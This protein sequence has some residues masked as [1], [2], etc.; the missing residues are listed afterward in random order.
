MDC[1]KVAKNIFKKMNKIYKWAIG[2]GLA[3]PVVAALSAHAAT[4]ATGD[5]SIPTSTVHD[6]LASVS[7]IFTDPGVL[8]L[9]VVAIAIPLAFYF[10][11]QAMGLMPKSRAR[12]S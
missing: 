3:S 2:L 12:R 11:H 1:V 10:A 8:A 9:V 6:L 7:V 4:I 5:L